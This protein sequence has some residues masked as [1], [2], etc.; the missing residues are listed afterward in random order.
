MSISTLRTLVLATP[1]VGPLVEL[2][3]LVLPLV[4]AIGSLI[5]D[6]RATAPTPA[7]TCQFE[8]SLAALLRQVGREMVTWV[9]NHLECLQDQ[10]SA[11]HLDFDG[12]RYRRRTRTE[13]RHGIATLFGIIALWRV[14][15]E[16]LEAGV[17]C[18]FPLEINLGITAARATPALAQR[19]GQWAAQH[20]QKNVLELLRHEHGVKWSVGTLRKVTAAISAGLAPSRH[21]AQVAKVLDLLKRAQSSRGP[22]RPVLAA[23][24]DGV[25]VP[26]SADRDYHEAAAGTLAVLDRRGRRLGTVYLGTMPEPGQA[27]LSEQLRALLSDVLASWQGPCPRLEYVT[28]GGHHPT[29]FYQKVLRKM[30]HPRTGAALE[31]QWVIDFYHA[32]GYLS[33]LAEALFGAGTGEAA[34]WAH[35]MRHWLQHWK[36]GLFRVLHSAAAHH[37]I[38]EL[39]AEEEKTYRS[40]YRYLSKRL[41]YM[42]YAGYRGR[43]LAIGSGVT[44]AACKTLFTQRFKQS[45]MQWSLEGGKV[46]VDLRVVWLS[47]VW[48]AVHQAYLE[49][50][51][52]PYWGTKRQ[53]TENSCGLAA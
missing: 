38:W 35:K 50:L 23:G 19:V 52:Q 40:A 22:H 48:D 47:G 25:F 45:G 8:N 41:K 34:R 10:Q 43:G 6:F 5:L 4:A 9:Y 29:E 33:K 13:R 49:Q 30:R 28:D 51:P 15:Y 12:E 16:P 39:S 11:E 7:A 42:D 17:P 44:E 14:R 46:I 2:A 37:Q 27:T 32:C 53:L 26:L 21:A 18:V 24:R 3:G 36:H 20:T 31:W 1:F